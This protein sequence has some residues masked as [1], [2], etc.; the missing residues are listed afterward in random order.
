LNF[1]ATIYIY[2]GDL[3]MNF[4]NDFDKLTA[5]FQRERVRE[6]LKQCTEAEKNLF[7][8]IYKSLDEVKAED[9]RNAYRLCFNTIKSKQQE[10]KK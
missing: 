1:Y 5:D 10:T 3:I 9:L 8:R 2:K 7:N 6:L 4:K